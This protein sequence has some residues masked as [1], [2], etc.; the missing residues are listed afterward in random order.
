MK[1]IIIT[2]WGILFCSSSAS[3]LFGIIMLSG[4]ILSAKQKKIGLKIQF[5]HPFEQVYMNMD[6]K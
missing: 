3:A 1:K 6:M 5:I 2:L 4:D